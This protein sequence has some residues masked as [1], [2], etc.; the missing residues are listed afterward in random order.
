M[1][2]LTDVNVA[3]LA[4]KKF[5]VTEEEAWSFVTDVQEQDRKDKEN[6]KKEKTEKRSKTFVI[7]VADPEGKLPKDLTG[8]MI[9]KLPTNHAENASSTSDLVAEKREWGDLE[10][11]AMVKLAVEEARMT[12]PKKGPFECVGDVIQYIPKKLLKSYGI[13]PITTEVVS[14]IGIAPDNLYQSGETKKDINDTVAVL[15]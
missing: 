12:C 13:K 1:A 7:M 5:K 8:F 11:E 4:Q 3:E 2:N 10:A 15:Q 9:E 14:I 6:N